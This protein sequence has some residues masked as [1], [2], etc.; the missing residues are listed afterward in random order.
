MLTQKRSMKRVGH[1]PRLAGSPV[2]HYAGELIDF[3]KGAR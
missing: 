2:G 3:E 1:V